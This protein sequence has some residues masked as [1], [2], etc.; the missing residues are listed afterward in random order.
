MYL[1]PYTEA[2]GPEVHPPHTNR[3]AGM[4]HGGCAYFIPVNIIVVMRL[5]PPVFAHPHPRV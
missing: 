3:A 2:G 4:G 5:V 1:V